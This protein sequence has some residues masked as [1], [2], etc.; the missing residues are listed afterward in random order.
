VE[1]TPPNP[2]AEAPRPAQGINFSDRQRTSHDANTE[3][4][5][6][7]STRA[8]ITDVETSEDGD[9][10]ESAN[11]EC[12]L[13]ATQ[14]CTTP[15]GS[16]G[17][18][19]CGKYWG[20]CIPPHESCNNKDDD[21]DGEVD[22]GMLNACG[23]CGELPPEVCNGKDDNCDGAVDEG[24]TNACGSCGALPQEVCNGKDDDCDGQVDEGV[25]NACGFCGP[26][27]KEE[28]CN[29][30]DDDCDGEVD[31]NCECQFDLNINGDCVYLKCPPQCPYP[32]S[33]NINMIGGDHRGCVASQP[34]SSVFYLQE[35]NLCGS[36]HITGQVTCSSVPGQGLKAGNCSINKPKKFY[37]NVVSGCPKTDD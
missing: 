36:G 33:C 11:Y 17:I 6:A 12:E 31:E 23:V 14:S 2:V 4:P 16:K 8:V 1:V 37:P 25:K 30:K 7:G 3:V 35:G 10:V 5:D 21:C 18:R 22:E 34:Q 26:I 19:Q 13:G 20:P 27:T 29:G 32:V 15:C 28:E 9:A 24:L